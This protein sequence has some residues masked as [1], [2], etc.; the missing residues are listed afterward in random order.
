MFMPGKST[1]SEETYFQECKKY[2]YSTIQKL[3][4]SKIFSVITTSFRENALCWS[5]KTFKM[6]QRKES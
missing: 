6:L 5:K 2:T 4:V 3:G 1:E